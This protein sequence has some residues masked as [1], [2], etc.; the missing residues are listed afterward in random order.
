MDADHRRRGVN[1]AH[2]QGYQ[3]LD[4][5]ALD[6]VGLAT[7]LRFVSPQGRGVANTPSKPKIL[8]APQRVGKSASA[9]F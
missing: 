9:I 6:F 3:P 8:K 4:L 1:V 7:V 2:H 5:A